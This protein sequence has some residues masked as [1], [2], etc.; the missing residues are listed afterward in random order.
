MINNLWNLD[1]NANKQYLQN[2][3]HE[4]LQKGLKFEYLALCYYKNQNY[5]VYLWSEIPSEIR[6]NWPKKDIG[7]DLIYRENSSQ[8]YV[9][10]QCKWRFTKALKLADIDHFSLAIKRLNL[11]N[12]NL[13]E[14]GIVFSNSTRKYKNIPFVNHIKLIGPHN[15][16]SKYFYIPE[17]TDFNLNITQP[18]EIR[19]YQKNCYEKM[20]ESYNL[21]NNAVKIIMCCGSGKSYVM[22]MFLERCIR[23][24]LSTNDIKKVCLFVPSIN[25]LNQFYD[26]CYILD[27]NK[28]ITL[29]G[30]SF[31]HDP[32]KLITISTYQS[33]KKLTGYFN[34]I[35]FD[36]AHHVNRKNN[37]SKLAHIYGESKQ[38]WFTATDNKIDLPLLYEYDFKK[39]ISEGVICD[40]DITLYKLPE[41]TKPTKHKTYSAA[42]YMLY[43]IHLNVS[44]KER[45][46]V[47]CN[48]IKNAEAF[49]NC[50]HSI[51]N[52]NIKTWFITGENSVSE[53]QS[54]FKE[55][56][57]YGG[58]L[59]SIKTIS[60]GVNLNCANNIMFLD[61]KGSGVDIVQTFSRGIRRYTD[62][63]TGETKKKANI[64]MPINIMSEKSD[65]ENI[66]YIL[67]S[68]KNTFDES[69]IKNRIKCGCIPGKTLEITYDLN[70]NLIELC[71]ITRKEHRIGL[72]IEVLNNLV[73]S[74][75]NY[76]LPKK[77]KKTNGDEWFNPED[78][79][80]FK[81]GFICSD[82]NSFNMY[83]FLND[84]KKKKQLHSL[85]T[86]TAI[87][88][89][90][91][92]NDKKFSDDL[93][94]ALLHYINTENNFEDIKKYYL[95]TKKHNQCKWSSKLQYNYKNK[96]YNIGEKLGAILKYYITNPE[97]IKKTYND[98]KILEILDIYVSKTKKQ[99]SVS[100]TCETLLE[101]LCNPE[102]Y[103]YKNL[104]YKG[105]NLE[106]AFYNT[107]KAF[108]KDPEL[109][110]EKRVKGSIMYVLKEHKKQDSDFK[111]SGP[112][113]RLYY[114]L[115]EKK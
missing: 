64:I 2:I 36:E 92:Y 91:D 88:T 75:G 53:R 113:S 59:I 6:K 55:L 102:N 39:G 82:V 74:E 44:Q 72:K 46:L 107:L 76:R 103:I 51:V 14:E 105:I 28:Y 21:N 99:D 5:E 68:L 47:F 85:F 40:F 57:I 80:L 61:P 29:N 7:V 43:K 15:I 1:F 89:Y 24:Y 38:F 79:P 94:E 54:V 106:N 96:C 83:K 115:K 90:F 33:F 23:Y 10:V 93:Y 110:I 50:L 70:F 95:G 66:E 67:Y 31:K 73:D 27:K 108:R 62:I 4:K 77:S 98:P 78:K 26:E 30:D 20:R 109:Q 101:Y 19:N 112:V 87:L 65:Y 71:K 16:E 9:P 81:T 84:C 63:I 13:V 49:K 42:A 17:N 8:K 45:T 111:Q 11:L 56:E 100:N 41:Y 69:F 12:N 52:N 18:L 60:E 3:Q 22:Y 34:F 37:I 97:F 86:N 104:V 35:I 25:L 114:M 58:I 48:S 32:E